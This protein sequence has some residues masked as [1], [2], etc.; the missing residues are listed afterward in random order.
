MARPDSQE[1][2]STIRALLQLARPF[3]GRFALIALLALLA[4][5]ADLI[6]PLIYRVAINDVAGLFVKPPEEESVEEPAPP[7]PEP[8]QQPKTTAQK[9]NTHKKGKAALR[10]PATREPHRRGHVASRTG[11]QTLT[12][13]LW[14]V[15]GLFVMSVIAQWLTLASEYQSTVVAN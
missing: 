11:E 10:P 8:Q 13:L 12:T 2:T 7:A 14:A 4:T 6:Q 1:R 15:V 9:S 5:A 3:K